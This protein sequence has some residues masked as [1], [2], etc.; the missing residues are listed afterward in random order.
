MDIKQ[1]SKKITSK[2]IETHYLE[3]ETFILE[4]KNIPVEELTLTVSD[5]L[6]TID[7]LEINGR[8]DNVVN[9]IIKAMD[10]LLFYYKKHIKIAERKKILKFI[11]KEY[12]IEKDEVDNKFEEALKNIGD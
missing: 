7:L 5:L 2:I 12:K 9:N 6:F 1:V 11:F 10:I 8:N 3:L 4:Y